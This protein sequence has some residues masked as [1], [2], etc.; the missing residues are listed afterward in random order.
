MDKGAEDTGSSMKNNNSSDGYVEERFLPIEL[1]TDILTR[2]PARSLGKCQCVCKLWRAIIQD[3]QF[4]RL[5]GKRSNPVF[6][7]IENT[8]VNGDEEPFSTQDYLEGMIL[9]KSN[10]LGKYR[11]RNPTTKYTLELPDP[12]GQRGL[13]RMFYLPNTDN[14]KLVYFHYKEGAKDGGCQVLTFETDLAWRTLD[15]ASLYNLG[16][17]GE[18]SY[19]RAIRDVVFVI[20]FFDAGLGSSQIVCLEMETEDF[21]HA[22]IPQELPTNLKDVKIL[23]WEQKFSL[24][25]LV[26]GELQ[27]WVLEDYKSE[28]WSKRKIVIPLTLFGKNPP[29]L[30][31]HSLC[32]YFNGCL[33]FFRHESLVSYHIESKFEF[34]QSAPPGK[35]LS[36]AFSPTPVNLL[37]NH[38]TTIHSPQIQIV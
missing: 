8:N 30:G 34:S 22:N 20:R 4:I 15:C 6:E 3:R 12:Q 33:W 2:L 13:M 7:Y 29:T 36:Y 26:E 31:T 17:N 1:L 38:L 16:D 25:N 11:I 18:R 14:Y 19:T 5:H 37:G 35:R 9:E 28:K 23:N 21:V 24:A 32:S 27:V 10:S